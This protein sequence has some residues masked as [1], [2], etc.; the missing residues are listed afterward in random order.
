MIG[1]VAGFQRTAAEAPFRSKLAGFCCAERR[2]P[3]LEQRSFR[4]LAVDPYA[5]GAELTIG[6]V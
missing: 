5:I 3:S 1:E 2:L 4:A 6:T